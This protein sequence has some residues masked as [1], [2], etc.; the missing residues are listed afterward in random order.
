MQ[1]PD[2]RSG[3]SARTP[4]YPSPIWVRWPPYSGQSACRNEQQENLPIALRSGQTR[5]GVSDAQQ[6]KIGGACDDVPERARPQRV[7]FDHPV[8][9]HVVGA[10]LEL[11]LDERDQLVPG[12]TARPP[13]AAS[14]RDER[15]VDHDRGRPAPADASG[16]RL[17]A[18]DA[19]RH[20]R[21]GRSER[22]VEL[23]VTDSMAT[24]ARRRAAADS[25]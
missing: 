17:R 12:A 19:R 1:L 3:D 16:C 6:S 8:S 14:Q 2:R 20:R 7:A 15:T 9:P 18:L 25:P 10:D 24:R 23:A 5:I 4:I 13:A 22:V 11:R 21:A